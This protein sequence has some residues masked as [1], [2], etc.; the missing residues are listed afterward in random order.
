MKSKP[1]IAI[2]GPG[3]LGTPMAL[4]LKAAGYRVAEVV[5]RPGASQRRA[6]NLAHAVQAKAVTVPEA[7]FDADVVWLT[8]GDT[9]I[10]SCAAELAA[11]RDWKGKTVLH[12]S[13]ALTS[14]ELS[15]LR[16]RGAAVA[17]LHPMMTFV[18]GVQPK[19]SGVVF[20]IEGDAAA[21][22]VA[23]SIA[24]E[25]GG[26]PVPIKASCKPL[27]HAFGAFTSPLIVAT[28]ATAELVA[29]KAGMSPRL[30]RAAIA[31]ILEQTVGNYLAHG[32][33]GAFSGP[34]VRG[35]VAT[36]RKHLRA[37]R[38]LPEARAVYLA[39]ARVALP[40]LPV[41]N[42]RELAAALGG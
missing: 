35:D 28:L 20:A 42:R 27:Y 40:E 19:L 14:R 12:A 24:S 37:L 26:R 25:L 22:R 32:P 6:R 23:R 1:T 33:A 5:Y 9:A 18:R 34:L 36:V 2:L 3:N 29:R 39:L 4:A 30:A 16:R 38:A 31:P 17:S 7:R 41:K 11:G 8:V 21:M 13:G 10:P 15:A